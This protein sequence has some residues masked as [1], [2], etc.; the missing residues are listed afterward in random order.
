MTQVELARRVGVSTNTVSNWTR[1]RYEPG[2]HRLQQIADAL[3]TSPAALLNEKPSAL[4]REVSEEGTAVEEY[5]RVVAAV[6]ALKIQ[7][8]LDAVGA[9]TPDLLRVL[10]DAR[11]LTEGG[12]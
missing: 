10:A 2:L 12:S 6:A 11:R 8:A 7:P 9:V 3:S 5:R 1:G 4:P